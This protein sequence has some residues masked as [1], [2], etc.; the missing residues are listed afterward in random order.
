MQNQGKGQGNTLPLSVLHCWKYCANGA[1]VKTF[2][3]FAE[4]LLLLDLQTVE[5]KLALQLWTGM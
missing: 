2:L 3:F 4:L 5:N 1:S